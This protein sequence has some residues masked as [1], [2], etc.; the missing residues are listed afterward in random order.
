ME[1]LTQWRMVLAANFLCRS[2]APL[3]RTA[4]DVGYRTDTAFASPIAH[5]GVKSSRGTAVIE[6]SE[7][8]PAHALLESAD[9]RKKLIRGSLSRSGLAH[10]R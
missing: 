3:A 2:N 4:E 9:A 5:I 7:I 1:Y 6:V 10:A 8:R